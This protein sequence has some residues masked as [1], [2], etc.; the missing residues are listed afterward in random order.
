MKKLAVALAVAI[1]ATGIATANMWFQLRTERE[2]A[3]QLTARVQELQTVSTV[4]PVAAAVPLPVPSASP[5]AAV[6]ALRNPLSLPV[7]ARRTQ[8]AAVSQ[9]PAAQATSEPIS[10]AKSTDPPMKGMLEVMTSPAGQDATRTLMRTMMARAYPDI[11][12]EL[13]L[14]SE[15]K[16]NLFDLLAKQGVNSASAMVGAQNSAS[17]QE[18]QRA[19]AESTRAAE[20]ETAALLGAKYPK[21]LEY[22]STAGARLLVEQLRLVLAASGD[23]LTE[24]Q[25]KDLVTAFAAEKKRAD[26]ETRD[27]SSSSAA[28]DSPNMMQ[29]MMQRTAQSQS[30]LVEAAAPIL[31]PAQLDRYKRQV[32]QQA[33]LLRATMGLLGGGGKP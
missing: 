9:Q 14:T 24:S 26:K 23:S 22:Q 1:L 27:W 7:S 21:W 29:E 32:E 10:A 33:A 13:G 19:M 25:S 31:Q 18:L 16:E 8:V 20:A 28:I 5:P 4:R 3:S 30:R 12:Q 11:E 2:K 6:A 15:E 17:K